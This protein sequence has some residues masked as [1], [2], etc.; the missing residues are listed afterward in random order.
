MYI[1]GH[2]LS[3][4]HS[5]LCLCSRQSCFLAFAGGA[6]F[7]S[8]WGCADLLADVQ[9][10]TY[11]PAQATAVPLCLRHTRRSF[12]SAVCQPWTSR[13]TGVPSSS[14]TS[15]SCDGSPFF[16]VM[17]PGLA[18]AR[19]QHFNTPRCHSR[20]RSGCRLQLTATAGCSGLDRNRRGFVL[21]SLA[22]RRN[23]RLFR[24]SGRKGTSS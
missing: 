16:T 19:L 20:H 15:Y 5:D 23:L 14:S 4:A 22:Q 1:W 8:A 11:R 6:R 10:W 2:A 24:P 13:V 3:I 9:G 17:R 12:A 7:L 18:N 21:G